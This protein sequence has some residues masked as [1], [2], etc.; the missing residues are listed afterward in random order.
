MVITVVALNILIAS[1]GF[2]VAWR[3]LQLRRALAK[4]ADAL[5]AAERSTH[6][7]LHDAPRFVLKGQGGVAQARHQY[8]KAA[9]QLEKAQKLIALLGLGQVVW[10]Q[11]RSVIPARQTRSLTLVAR[12]IRSGVRG[13]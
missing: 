9:I 6:S 8:R 4:A 2:Y 10:R 3:L 11:Y 12:M 13:A 1:L 7:A 5:I